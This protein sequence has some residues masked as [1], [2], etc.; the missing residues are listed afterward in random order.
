MDSM[1]KICTHEGEGR[2]QHPVEFPPHRALR[3][4]NGQ[5]GLEGHTTGGDV[6]GGG[7]GQ[8]GGSGRRGSE[9]QSVQAQFNG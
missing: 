3:L 8:Q 2:G 4:Q 9:Q 5:A 7:C 6:S 1:L